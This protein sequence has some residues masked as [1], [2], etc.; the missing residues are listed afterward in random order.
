MK[1]ILLGL[2]ALAFVVGFT[3]SLAFA[4]C[5][6][7]YKCGKN[8]APLIPNTPPPKKKPQSLP[9]QAPILPAR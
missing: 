9:N 3:P 2:I 1:K 6:K 8:D 7:G 5:P 4:K